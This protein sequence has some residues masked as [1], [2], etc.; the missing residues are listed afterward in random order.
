MSEVDDLPPV[1]VDALRAAGA[2]LVDVR[3]ADEWDAGRIPGTTHLP[4]SELPQRWRELPEAERTVFICRSGGRSMAAAEAFAAAGRPGCAN[5]M[6]G[7][8][9]WAQAG[10]PFDGTV[11]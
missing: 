4:L 8:A 2:L 9:A 1:E 6:G 11:A 10:L 5:L 7:V 3:E